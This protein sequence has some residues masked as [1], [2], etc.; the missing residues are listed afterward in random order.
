MQ[1]EAKFGLFIFSE[2]PKYKQ[3]YV[4]LNSFSW[5]TFTPFIFHTG[6]SE[7]REGSTKEPEQHN[8]Q[9]QLPGCL[10]GAAHVLRNARQ[11]FLP[12]EA[13]GRKIWE[14]SSVRCRQDS[15]LV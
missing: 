2:F 6:L 15:Q 1:K 13:G 14:I 8:Q 11:I 5:K 7:K 9:Q 3:Q 4:A 12:S 10:R